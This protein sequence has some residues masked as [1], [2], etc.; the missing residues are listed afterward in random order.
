MK[1]SCA[2]TFDIS[3]PKSWARRHLGLFNAGTRIVQALERKGIEAETLEPLSRKNGPINK[4]K[5]LFYQRVYNRD[6]CSW[7]EPSISKQYARQ[8][9][10]QLAQSDADILLCLENAIPLAMV[11]PDRPMVLWTDTTLG[12]L[13]DFYPHMSNLCRKS[14]ANVLKMEK[15]VLD[16]CSLLI[17]NSNWAA[18]K[19]RELYDI[20]L[21]KIEVI[22][23]VSSLANSHSK[24]DIQVAADIQ[25]AIALRKTSTCQLLFIGVDW[26]R[27]GGETA[28][29]VAALLN[30]KG[31]KTELHIVGCKPA[32]KMPSFVRFHG[33]I[34]RTTAAGFKKLDELFKSAHFLIYPTRA[35]ALGL[36]LSEAGAYGVPALA[37]NVGG[38]SDLV[39]ANITGKTFALTSD[40]INS[41]INS[42]YEFI[43]GY[44]KDRERYMALANSTLDYYSDYASESAVGS[45]A[46]T[47]FESLLRK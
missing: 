45:R 11:N 47:A 7:A 10:N 17:V 13:I 30:E 26:Q 12:S 18:N 36:A 21:E 23:R 40:V 46:K 19:A 44:L 43:V 16:K 1:V 41:N 2:T 39:K 32:R 5:W 27:K 33:F 38:I 9:H 6:F 24:A 37:T 31:M 15:N 34:D 22:P 29:A 35:D 3:K 4:L 20:P 42:Y 28:L 8:I 25:A 14:K